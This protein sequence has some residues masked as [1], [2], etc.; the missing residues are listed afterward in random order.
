MSWWPRKVTVFD[1]EYHQ[2]ENG[3][4][5]PD[6]VV[7]T[8]LEID[9]AGA[10]R[11][12]G[13]FVSCGWEEMRTMATPPWDTS[14]DNVL[15]AFSGHG[16]LQCLDRLGWPR[17]VR[18]VDLMIELRNFHNG[19]HGVPLRQG[20]YGYLDRWGIGHPPESYKSD[21]RDLIIS[22]QSHTR[23]AEVLEYCRSDVEL[24]ASLVALVASR[25][26]WRRAIGHRGPFM[27][28]ISI[29]ESRG[30]PVDVELV[31]RLH[32]HWPEIQT[33]A[34]SWVNET[35][36]TEIY[37]GSGTFTISAMEQWLA[38]RGLLEGWPR[39]GKSGQIQLDDGTLRDWSKMS[40][41]FAVLYES[42]RIL[43]QG[44][45]GLRL[46]I[47][48]DGR[49]RTWLNP[50]GTKTG[51]NAPREPGGFGA[52]GGPFLFAGARWVRGLLKPEPG[53][54]LA[55]I[56]WV[57]QEIQVG[58]A[59]SGD[60]NLIACYSSPDPYVTF[61]I[62][63]RAV[64]ESATKKTHPKER[65]IFKTTLLGLGY[66]MGARTLAYRLGTTLH[67]AEMLIRL[68]RRVFARYWAWNEMAVD[69]ARRT[70]FISN[71]MG[72]R[73][74]VTAH[75]TPTTLKN[76]PVQAT[77]AAMLQTAVPMIERAGV[78]VLA[79]VH[80][81]VLIEADQG[82]I[83]AA[84]ERATHAME[85]ASR[86]VTG[87]NLTCRTDPKI[88]RYPDRYMDDDGAEMFHRVV[89]ELDRIESRARSR[90]KSGR[91]TG[92]T[93]IGANVTI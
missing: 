74:I 79:T 65:S 76:W 11:G 26:D 35:F 67:E 72:W 87:S 90:A 33:G 78:R 27:N 28:A 24:T 71:P 36:R 82:E 29:A 64:P 81:A 13:F 17:P 21:I 46:D 44:A 86:I 77:G 43:D 54:A 48:A 8:T 3:L 69:H 37:S 62:L 2:D 41:E 45:D 91:A 63:A 56:D 92:L 20:L 55:Y 70:G 80:D 49:C 73:M 30:L 84:V 57:S 51:R 85:S 52:R 83:E 10:V 61:A 18:F 6:C 40:R 68:H 47:G 5:V 12:S 50:F 34:R 23:P 22:G 9:D 58:A 66:G 7:A 19:T 60:E 39:T 32:R 31:T 53:R 16:D 59:L 1:F 89:G 15:V 14:P 42:R 4:P 88:V 25:I 93:K 38:D 75:T